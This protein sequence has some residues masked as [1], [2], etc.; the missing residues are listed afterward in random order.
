MLCQLVL[1]CYYDGIGDGANNRVFTHLDANGFCGVLRGTCRK[2]FDNLRFWADACLVKSWCIWKVQLHLMMLNV[3]WSHLGSLKKGFRK[4]LTLVL[5]LSLDLNFKTAW[6][7][8]IWIWIWIWI[9]ICCLPKN[10][11][12]FLGFMLGLSESSVL[13]GGD[14]SDDVGHDGQIR[15]FS[16]CTKWSWWRLC[17]WWRCPDAICVGRNFASS[18]E[19][20]IRITKLCPWI[21]TSRL[22][23]GILSWVIVLRGVL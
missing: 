23:S 14:L 20:A 11:T 5:D 10:D 1:R 17:N 13:I 15:T 6:C 9:W 22:G 12:R 19:A 4:Q 2:S 7:T 3:D 21:T 8:G 16:T 18:P